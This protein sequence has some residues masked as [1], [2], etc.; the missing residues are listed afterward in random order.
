[1]TPSIFY[2]FNW[3]EQT[4][5]SIWMRES[6]SVLAFPNVLFLH[7]L[8]MAFLAGTNAAVDLRVLGFA[9]EMRL[10]PMEK[11][12]PL[13]WSSF[14]VM[15]VTGLLL[16]FAYPTKAFTNPVWYVKFAFIALALWNTRSIQNQMFRD[17]RLD[18][19]PMPRQWKVLASTSLIFWAGAIT[20]GKLLAHTYTRLYAH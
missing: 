19:Q 20:A 17:P 8:A 14:W 6:P 3:I 1:M 18:A 13:M 11:F 2:W 15:L 10:A 12:F 16:L 7:T 4:R 5:F 9:P